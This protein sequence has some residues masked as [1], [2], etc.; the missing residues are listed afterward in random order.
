MRI[1]IGLYYMKVMNIFI[2]KNM[3]CKHQMAVISVRIDDEIEEKL[4]FIMNKRKAV[5][6]SSMIRHILNNSLDDEII[7]ILCG[8]VKNKQISAWKAASIAKISLRK[9]LDELGKREIPSYD[10]IAMD[11]DLEYLRM[12]HESNN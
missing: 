11:D 6:K 2:Y 9:M 8:E 7:E 5:D 4:E 1:S 12:K 3:Y 10:E